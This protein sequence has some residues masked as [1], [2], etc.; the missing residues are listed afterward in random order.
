[1]YSTAYTKSI[2]QILFC[3][4]C[5]LGS[6]TAFPSL[7]N[8]GICIY[9]VEY[10]L[11][12]SSNRPLRFCSFSSKPKS[13]FQLYLHPQIGRF[14]CQLSHENVL[15]NSEHCMQDAPM[16]T[17]TPIKKIHKIQHFVTICQ[18]SLTEI[19]NFHEQNHFITIAYN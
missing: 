19:S 18:K 5:I 16:N 15:Q 17:G 13:T 6:G 11:D 4:V 2:V 12:K 8:H 1:M 7:P 9:C 3:N 14:V 10:I